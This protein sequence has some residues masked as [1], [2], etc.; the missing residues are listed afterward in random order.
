[1]M[2][3]LV[4]IDGSSSLT[5]LQRDE[6]ARARPDRRVEPRHRLQIVVEH[7]RPR[8]DHDLQRALLVLEVGGQD[9]DR[10]LRR[11]GPHRVDHVGEVLRPAVGQV[12]AVD[13]GDDDVIEAEL[14]TGLG[15][16]LRLVGV[17]LVGPA[18]G[19]VA[20]RAGAGANRAQDHHRG[21]ALRPALPDV[22]AG[23]LLAHRVELERAHQLARLAVFRRG[24]RLDP[25]PRRL[26]LDRV[27]RAVCLLRMANAGGGRSVC[28]SIS[29]DVS[30]IGPAPRRSTARFAAPSGLGHPV[31]S[32][33]M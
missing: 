20:E 22:R 30:D 10:R 16:V 7:V 8:L 15:D 2:P 6:V 31:R 12:V 27:V 23:R 3:D 32:S 9:L 24:R 28:I 1:M 29:H 19:D 21:M 14:G 13:R 18:G 4:K 25:D 11:R 5:R 26:A 33:A 17:E